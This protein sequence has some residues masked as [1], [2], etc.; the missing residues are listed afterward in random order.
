MAMTVS[1]VNALDIDCG[2]VMVVCSCGR[3]EEEK[4]TRGNAAKF[5]VKNKADEVYPE[6]RARRK[7]S[8]STRWSSSTLATISYN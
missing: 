5:D 3:G 6:L 8:G 2:G 7:V 4:G 1:G